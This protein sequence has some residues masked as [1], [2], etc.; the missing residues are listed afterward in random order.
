MKAGD[1][2]LLLLIIDGRCE[3][4]ALFDID[5]FKLLVVDHSVMQC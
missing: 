3:R 4:V 1:V 5:C 2:T